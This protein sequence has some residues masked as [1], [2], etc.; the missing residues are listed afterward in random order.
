MFDSA[1]ECDGL[2]LNKLL[3]SGP[4]ITNLFRVL[5]RFRENPVAMVADIEQMFHS[6]RVKEEHRD[7]LR[8]LWYKDNDPNGEITEYRIKVHIIR[9][10]SSPAVANHGLRKTAEVGEAD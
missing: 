4:D 10:T 7:P 9:N 5:L 2:S 3:L 1:A 6:F 8:F